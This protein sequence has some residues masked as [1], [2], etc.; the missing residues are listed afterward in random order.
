MTDNNKASVLKIVGVVALYWFISISMVFA[1][2]QL[3]GGQVFINI[4]VFY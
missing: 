2:K 4:I 3:L 1:N